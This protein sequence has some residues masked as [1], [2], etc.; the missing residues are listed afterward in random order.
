MIWVVGVLSIYAQLLFPSLLG[1]FNVP[2]KMPWLEHGLFDH[3]RYLDT[4]QITMREEDTTHDLV[5]VK[6]SMQVSQ[7]QTVVS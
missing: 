4:M 2:L 6:R 5:L 3:K 1:L 7:K